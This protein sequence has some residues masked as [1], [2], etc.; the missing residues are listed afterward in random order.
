LKFYSAWQLKCDQIVLDQP[1]LVLSQ[2][3]NS[4]GQVA[5]LNRLCD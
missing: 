4:R 5:N 1:M 2:L 3:L